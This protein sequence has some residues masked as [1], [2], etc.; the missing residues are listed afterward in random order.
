V[1]AGGGDT[2]NS[3]KDL[4]RRENLWTVGVLA[5]VVLMM[6]LVA[7]AQS[8]AP[9]ITPDPGPM[10]PAINSNRWLNTKRLTTAD[11]RGKVV[12]VE[13]WAFDCINCQRTV[14]AMKKLD[15]AYA[16][17]EVVIVGV[18]TPELDAERVFSNV[19]KAVAKL[20]LAYPIAIDN[21]YKIWN[22][23]ENHY[24]PALYVV[25][26]HGFI[27][28]THVGELHEG[29]PG[30]DQVVRWIDELRKEPA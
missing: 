6:I 13:F 7:A 24:W 21:D 11:L 17:T 30:W 29:T 8:K 23:Y 19:Q 2:L 20:G 10:A 12:L 28:H 9:V 5:H 25:D 14:P 15:S 27:R 26:K 4:M 1:Q 18:H 16:D 3:E 22:S